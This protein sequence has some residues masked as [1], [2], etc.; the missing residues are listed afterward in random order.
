MEQN[1]NLRKIESDYGLEDGELDGKDIDEIE[2]ICGEEEG[3]LDCYNIDNYCDVDDVINWISEHDQLYEDFKEE[4][5]YEYNESSGKETNKP[6]NVE[7]IIDWL[8]DHETA[9]EDFIE[10]FEIP[11]CLADSWR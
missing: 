4:F 10:Y 3:A 9:F 5:E 6:N 11:D 1:L 7:D 2:D 8:A